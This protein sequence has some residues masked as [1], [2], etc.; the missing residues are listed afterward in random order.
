MSLFYAPGM[1]PTSRGSLWQ[2]R[3]DGT[4]NPILQLR[5]A[6]SPALHEQ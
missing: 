6:G 5:P 1:Q 4:V 3:Q 2:L